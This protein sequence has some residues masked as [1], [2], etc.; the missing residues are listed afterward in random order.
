MYLTLS[1]D[2]IRSALQ[3]LTDAQYLTA[4]AYYNQRDFVK[5]DQAARQIFKTYPSG[6]LPADTRAKVE[7]LVD[8]V[9]RAEAIAR[10]D[11][12][13]ITLREEVSFNK[14]FE[15]DFPARVTLDNGT[16]PSPDGQYLIKTKAPTGKSPGL[17]WGKVQGPRADVKYQWIPGSQGAVF[18][19]W[20][21]NSQEFVYRRAAGIQ[22]VLDKYDLKTRKSQTLFSTPADSLG[23]QSD[24]H[25]AANKIAFIYA[26]SVWIINANGTNKSMLKTKQKINYTAQIR[27]ST[28]GTMIHFLQQDAKGKP[29]EGVLILDIIKLEH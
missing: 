3:T 6:F 29:V 1:R 18:P 24:Y 16:S 26:G 2:G 11:A 7:T 4:T 14:S 8:R 27:W 12:M 21:P 19:V 9:G 17:Y 15:A 28:D 25:P 5:A 20:S 22:H 10:A 23:I 13:M